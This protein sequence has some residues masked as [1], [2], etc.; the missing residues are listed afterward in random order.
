MKKICPSASDRARFRILR[1]FTHCRARRR[2]SSCHSLSLHRSPGL[3][4]GPLIDRPTGNKPAGFLAQRGA[5]VCP[6]RGQQNRFDRGI[7][8]NPSSGQSDGMGSHMRIRIVCN[9]S[10]RPRQNSCLVG[11]TRALLAPVARQRVQGR[12]TNPSVGVIEHRHQVVHD[13][14]HEEVIQK[15]PW[16]RSGRRAVAFGPEQREPA[17][18]AAL[19]AVP[20]PVMTFATREAA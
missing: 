19:A 2:S 7:R 6:H 1:G 11:A 9:K 4:S 15:R 14:G 18:R 8:M 3:W 16:G 10:N 13:L 17:V 5:W 20:L 12:T